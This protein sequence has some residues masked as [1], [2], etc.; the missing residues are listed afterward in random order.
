[1]FLSKSGDR[2]AWVHARAHQCRGRV[3]AARGK[4]TEAGKP[5]HRRCCHLDAPHYNSCGEPPTK[6]E[7]GRVNHSTAHGQAP[8]SRPRSRRRRRASTGCS[9]WP[10][11]GRRLRALRVSHRGSVFCGAFVWARRPLNGRKRRLPPPRAEAQALRGLTE[12]VLEPAGRGAAGRERL[13]RAMEMVACTPAEL[14]T[15]S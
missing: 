13:A 1:M 3:L 5:G 9:V 10:H 15:L 7:Q 8:P 4:H 12:H 14:A 6:Y 11:P 2:R